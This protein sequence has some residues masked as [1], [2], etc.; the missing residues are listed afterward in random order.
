MDG[1]AL[2]Q[3]YEDGVPQGVSHQLSGEISQFKSLPQE[4]RAH[5]M[6]NCAWRSTEW[7][8]VPRPMAP[9]AHADRIRSTKCESA[10]N[11]LGWTRLTSM[12]SSACLPCVSVRSATCATRCYDE[13]SLTVAP[14]V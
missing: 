6:A 10:Q 14:L 13:R 7:G 8:A 2:S 12:R 3:A 5:I 9:P 4:L 11:P 1:Q